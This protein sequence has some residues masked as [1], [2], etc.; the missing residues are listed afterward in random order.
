[1]LQLAPDPSLTLEAFQDGQMIIS[2]SQGAGLLA[3]VQKAGPSDVAEIQSWYEENTSDQPTYANDPKWKDWWINAL[4]TPQLGFDIYK[5]CHTNERDSVEC[6]GFMA[7]KRVEDWLDCGR[8]TIY[9]NGLRINPNLMPNDET[10]RRYKGVGTA[11]ITFAVAE[12]LRDKN[13]VGITVNSSIGVEGFYR[14]L[15]MQEQLASDGKRSSF[16]IKDDARKS[17]IEHQYSRAVGLL[18]T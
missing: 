11:L 18:K 5:L 9:I 12:S 17:F 14:S 7:L 8:P 16:S 10:E 13:C 15:N 3:S 6:L 4:S 2:N 1:M